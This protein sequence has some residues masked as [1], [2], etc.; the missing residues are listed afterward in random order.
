MK[1]DPEDVVEASDQHETT[2]LPEPYFAK[3]KRF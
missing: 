3:W 1:N 2:P